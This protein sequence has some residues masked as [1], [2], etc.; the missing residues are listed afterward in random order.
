M[1]FSEEANTS[2]YCAVSSAPCRPVRGPG[3]LDRK[4]KV[5]EI[6]LLGEPNTFSYWMNPGHEDGMGLK[7]IMSCVIN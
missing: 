3:V 1:V 4:M 2:S 5:P 7:M 6:V